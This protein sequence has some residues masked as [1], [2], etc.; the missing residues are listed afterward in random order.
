MVFKF[1]T[2]AI[3]VM[4][5][6]IFTTLAKRFTKSPTTPTRVGRKQV[7]KARKCCIFYNKSH[8]SLDFT[9]KVLYNK[10]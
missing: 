9:T 4:H 6:V 3:A 2:N 8:N 1:F 5:D 10:A 7:Q